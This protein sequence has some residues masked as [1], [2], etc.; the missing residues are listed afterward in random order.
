MGLFYIFFLI[1]FLK[2][3]TYLK[4]ASQMEIEHDLRSRRIMPNGQKQAQMRQ[5]VSNF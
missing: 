1:N 4:H 3:F 2:N 5:T